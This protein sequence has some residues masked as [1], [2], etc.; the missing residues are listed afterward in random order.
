[1]TKPYI[2]QSFYQKLLSTSKD[3]LVKAILGATPI[4]ENGI[5]SHTSTMLHAF[6]LALVPSFVFTKLVA[7]YTNAN[8]QKIIKLDL[9]LFV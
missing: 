5:F 2:C 8:L 3:K 9:K 7:K 4:N 6:T 1:M